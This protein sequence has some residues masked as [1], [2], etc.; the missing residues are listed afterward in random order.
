MSVR[1]L[2]A[3][4]VAGIAALAA[5]CTASTQSPIRIV[6][7]ARRP[8]WFGTYPFLERAALLEA[9]GPLMEH[10]SRTLG[11]TVRVRVASSYNDL[12]RA[13][14]QGRV[15]VGWFTP[16]GGE[17]Q[18]LCRP[19]S[20]GGRPHR[21]V[22]VARKSDGPMTLASLAGKR[23]LYVDRFSRS[24]Y[25]YPNRLFSAR[26]IDPL[27]YFGSIGFAGNHDRVLEQLLSGAADAGAVSDTLEHDPRRAQVFESRIAVIDRTDPIPDDPIVV[28]ATLDEQLKRDLREALLGLS[29]TA[30]GRQA[31]GRLT[32]SLGV[33]RFE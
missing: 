20:P 2:I 21:G 18:R 17:M 7:E 33:E 14:R 11:R 8:L 27:R 31:L 16:T 29:A 26:G 12:D 1:C 4:L 25:L 19:A 9:L 30:G 3:A 32:A 13:I 5:G 6:H 24:G 10:L 23:F 15:D 22:I 28:L